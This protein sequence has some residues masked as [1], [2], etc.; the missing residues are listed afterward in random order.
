M[1]VQEEKPPFQLK[2][3]FQQNPLFQI[4]NLELNNIIKFS[5][6]YEYFWV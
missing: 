3:L 6:W 2:P 5:I 4:C 1:S